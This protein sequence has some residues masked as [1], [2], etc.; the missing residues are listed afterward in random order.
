MADEPL[1][2][3]NLLTTAALAL[4]TAVNRAIGDT[5][6]FLVHTRDPRLPYDT[7]FNPKPPPCYNI[8]S[9][10]AYICN[11]NRKVFRQVRH[12]LERAQ[13]ENKVS[14]DARFR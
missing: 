4:N 10:R 3:P 2:W 8:E 1:T 14:Y 6:Y 11:Q 12:M 9:Y 7:L 5:P 13:E